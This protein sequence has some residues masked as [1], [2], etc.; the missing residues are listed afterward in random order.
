MTNS[1]DASPVR[2]LDVAGTSTPNA[3]RYRHA[4]AML[5]IN[6]QGLPVAWR[7]IHVLQSGAFRSHA[8]QVI[9]P[10]GITDVSADTGRRQR[11]AC[12]PLN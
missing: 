9:T 3:R 8:Y 2:S 10:R 7:R 1:N 4:N 5:R 12:F 6:P 11:N